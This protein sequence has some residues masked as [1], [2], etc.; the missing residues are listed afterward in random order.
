[1]CTTVALA[2][3]L[4]VLA[5]GSTLTILS[6]RY[7]TART[8]LVCLK[9]WEIL[10]LKVG[11]YGKLR[12]RDLSSNTIHTSTDSESEEE[13]KDEPVPTSKLLKE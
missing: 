7:H 6:G 2:A 10:T 13:A 9:D 4:P 3:S 5:D 12:G 11:V 1:M 8:F